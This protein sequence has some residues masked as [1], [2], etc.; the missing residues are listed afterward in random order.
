MHGVTCDLHGCYIAEIIILL[1]VY[2][3]LSNACLGMFD[4]LKPLCSTSC[5]WALSKYLFC[6]SFL[7]ELRSTFKVLQR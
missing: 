1:L 3:T 6:N 7:Q 5:F 4:S 2:H